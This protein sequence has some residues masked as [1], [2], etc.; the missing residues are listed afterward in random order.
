MCKR[1]PIMNICILTFDYP[2]HPVYGS[3]VYVDFLTKLLRESN[4]N[5]QIVTVNRFELL[6]DSDAIFGRC[7]HVKE[8]TEVG[9]CVCSFDSMRCLSGLVR[10]VV[11]RFKT[12]SFVPDVLYING[13]MFFDLACQLRGYYTNVKVICAIHYLVEQ[14][15][16]PKDDPERKKIYNKESE[17]IECSD[18]I[19]CFSSLALD[20]IE[21][22]NICNKDKLYLIPHACNVDVFRRNFTN[23]HKFVFASRLE[24]GKGI[25]QLCEAMCQID[26]YFSL[27]ILGTGRL[28]QTIIEK[29]GKR[30]TIHGY[31]DKTF[32]LEKLKKSDF[33]ILPSYS[34]HCPMI[35]LEGMASGC[36][37]ILSNFGYIPELIKQ[38]NSGLVFDI[39]NDEYL[40]IKA[41]SNTIK[42]AL[43][44]KSKEANRMIKTNYD[45][46]HRYFSPEIMKRK[47]LEVFEN[48][49]K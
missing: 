15:N 7:L 4:H 24:P 35:V 27:D 44:I 16:V 17:M 39:N 11:E 20:L 38:H 8:T 14:D 1:E 3:G 40:F 18:G 33:F 48:A 30:F 19:I 26:D 23:N 32:V 37:P 34:E 46:L 13:Y 36:I 43:E 31:K 45:L 47:T 42:T 41:I 29:Y 5:V 6:K 28:N 21:N 10:I 25:E 2:P 9:K 12:N 49:T 22:R